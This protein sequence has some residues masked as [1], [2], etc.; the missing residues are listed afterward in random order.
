MNNVGQAIRQGKT[1]HAYR[2]CTDDDKGGEGVAAVGV[3]S[4]PSFLSRL[5]LI[6][7]LEARAVPQWTP[8]RKLRMVAP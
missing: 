8:P 4:F 2:N 5:L 3:L 1:D 6:I 7:L